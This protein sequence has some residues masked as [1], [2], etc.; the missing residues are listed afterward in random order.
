VLS[1]SLPSVVA[2]GAL[3]FLFLLL[4]RSRAFFCRIG[5]SLQEAFLHHHPH[6]IRHPVVVNHH[7]SRQVQAFHHQEEHLRDLKVL[8]VFEDQNHQMDHH[9]ALVVAPHHQGPQVPALPLQVVNPLESPLS[10]PPR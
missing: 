3:R 5:R 2:V 10:V 1:R 4:A 8:I 6:Q 7:P 9:L